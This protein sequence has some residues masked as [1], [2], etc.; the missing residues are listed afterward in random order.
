M[1]KI[2]AI[3]EMIK[4]QHT[5]F[6]LPFAILSACTAA[7]GWPSAHQALWILAAMVGA[8]SA[9]MA[10]N[11]LADMKY[12]ALNPR[13]QQRA[14][15][16]GQVSYA[17][18]ALFTIAMSALFF[19]SA[20]MLNT[21]CFA[22]SPA[23]L[24]ILLG[25]SYTKR[26][27]LLSHFA[28]GLSLGL[29]PVGAWLAIRETFDLF[30]VLLGAAVTLWTAGFDILYS[31]EDVEFDRQVGLHSVPARFGIPAAMIVSSILHILVIALLFALAPIFHLGWIYLT[32]CGVISALLLYEHLLVKSDDLQ[33][34]NRAFFTVNAWVSAIL[35]TAGLLDLF[36]N[37]P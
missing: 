10:F 33:K 32:G 1:R 15:P 11:R 14:L 5:L 26:F 13:T 24:F 34:L 18:T 36:L 25:Y 21:T 22:L 8:R 35:M 29:A 27:T 20:Y 16:T 19:V 3:L 2:I 7:E 37:R 4:F 30:P 9:S 17:A 28:L 31:C 23:V 6:A 12:D